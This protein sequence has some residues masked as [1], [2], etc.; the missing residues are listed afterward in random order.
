MAR[1]RTRRSAP[2]RSVRTVY[3]SAGRRARRAGRSIVKSDLMGTLIGGAGY[4]A[5]RAPIA[6]AISPLTSKIPLP[7]GYND[8]IGLALVSYF[9]AKQ[10]GIIGK[11]GKAG[12]TVEAASMGSQLVNK[13]L[14]GAGM[15]G[16]ST[17]SGG[18]S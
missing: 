18:W 14:I 3:R 5:L 7:G 2:R 9:A 17:S 8:E 13:G 16:G 4:G 10:G 6:N 1:R 12:L 15:T 11:M